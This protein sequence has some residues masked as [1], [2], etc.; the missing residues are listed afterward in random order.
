MRA[1]AGQAPLYLHHGQDEVDQRA[2]IQ[3]AIPGIVP[4]PLSVL[5]RPTKTGA[6]TGKR[7]SRTPLRTW[8]RRMP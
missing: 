2:D 5:F 4:E 3:Q 8:C 7:E 1:H 6:R